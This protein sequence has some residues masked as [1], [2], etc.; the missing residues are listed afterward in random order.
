LQSLRQYLTRIFISI[1]Y[2]NPSEEFEQTAE[3]YFSIFPDKIVVKNTEEALKRV[4][5]IKEGLIL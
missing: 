2:Q 1:L 5:K 3:A 4:R